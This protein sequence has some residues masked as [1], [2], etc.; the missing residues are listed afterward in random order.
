MVGDEY[1]F[2]VVKC[3][4]AV[5]KGYGRDVA[6]IQLTPV[7]QSQRPS[8]PFLPLTVQEGGQTR[9]AATPHFGPLPSLFPIV[10][11]GGALRRGETLQVAG[12][13]KISGAPIQPQSTFGGQVVEITRARDGTMVA[14]IDSPGGGRPQDGDSGSPVLGD[15]GKVAGMWTWFDAVAP[16]ISY[17]QTL[18][19]VMPACR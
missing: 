10:Q 12:Y 11:M 6:E 17:A 13:G 19:A 14:K 9:V 7:D 3:A 2:A 16:Q 8:S 5:P 1:Y 15:D 4:S 18:E